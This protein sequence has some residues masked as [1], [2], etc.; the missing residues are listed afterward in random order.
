MVPKYPFTVRQP[1]AV[2]LQARWMDESGRYDGEYVG[3][4]YGAATSIL[5]YDDHL[6]LS[7]HINY[8]T[9]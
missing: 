6:Y 7:P 9:N 2:V 5:E 3:K 4:R 1:Q 8:S